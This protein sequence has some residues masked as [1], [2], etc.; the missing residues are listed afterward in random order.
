MLK[1]IHLWM[2][3]V[4]FKAVTDIYRME[5]QLKEVFNCVLSVLKWNLG[6]PRSTKWS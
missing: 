5:Q 1:N 4:C 3:K 2:L 6:R